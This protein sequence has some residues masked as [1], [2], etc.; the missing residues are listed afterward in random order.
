MYAKWTSFGTGGEE[1][2]TQALSTMVV[3][4]QRAKGDGN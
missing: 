4:E 2:L 1:I 3:V